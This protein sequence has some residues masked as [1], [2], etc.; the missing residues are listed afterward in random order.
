MGCSLCK[1]AAG[2]RDK[3]SSQS[4]TGAVLSSIVNHLSHH[5]KPK[6]NV[7]ET[8]KARYDRDA[9]G[10]KTLN[11]YVYQK[12]L[13]V[14]S[15]GKV[16]LYLNNENNQLYA[17]KSMKKKILMKRRFGV[18]NGRTHWDDVM[19]EISIMKR[20]DHPN[21]IKVFEIINDP[22]DTK[23][24]IVM[25]YAENGPL[26]KGEDTDSYVRSIDDDT[27]KNYFAQ[28]VKGLQY[29]HS[30]GVIHRDIKPENIL[31]SN[32]VIKIADFGVSYQLCNRSIDFNS[33]HNNGDEDSEQLKKSVGSPAFLPP[34][35]CATDHDHITGPPIDIWALGITLFFLYFG[36]IPFT[37]DTEAI[38]YDN[39][40][41]QDLTFPAPA[42]ELLEDLLKKL[43]Q[44][45]PDLRITLDSVA[46]H[47]W[48]KVERE[49]EEER[50]I[51]ERKDCLR[52]IMERLHRRLIYF[53]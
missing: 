28:M 35:L 49:M 50:D 15:F 42:D 25:E 13:G 27:M 33:D 10:V 51:E 6:Y 17:V 41:T 24:H 45:N 19:R 30:R 11:Q 18:H 44:K 5:D 23:I 22:N 7:R 14:G 43:L 40:R 3:R 12:K 2:R 32:G 29:V 16:S 46:Q 34:E 4:S 47:P 37:G 39:V 9:C 21:V 31:A 1:G 8:K 20:L 26:F 52:P 48:D 53:R 36:R 38:L